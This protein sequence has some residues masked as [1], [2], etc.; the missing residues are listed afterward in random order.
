MK[1]YGDCL[2]RVHS[3]QMVLGT[4][5][6]GGWTVSAVAKGT[7]K[8][9]YSK[10]KAGYQARVHSDQIVLVMARWEAGTQ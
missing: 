10:F 5:R 9:S 4:V 1:V 2:K 7:K 3:D 8:L 6:H